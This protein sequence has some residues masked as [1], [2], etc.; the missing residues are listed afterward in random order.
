MDEENNLQ[1]QENEQVQEPVEETVQEQVEEVVEET[2]EATDEV[3]EEVVEEPVEEAAEE[4][5]E[6]VV[7][8]PATETVQEPV[9]SNTTTTT[10]ETKSSKKGL[11]IGIIV[12]VVVI[13]AVVAAVL[14]F[15]KNGGKSIAGK[16]SLVEMTEGEETYSQE[17]LKALEVFGLTVSLELNE[18][19]T[20]KL[21]LFGEEMNLT[22]DD[23]NMYYEGQ[24]AP[25]KV[26]GKKV[27][28][29][30][31]GAKMTFEKNENK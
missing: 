27:S 19:K 22:Y 13:A 9:E 1:E 10:V 11:I 16:Y 8:E 21:V 26:D 17:Q 4:V 30:Q 14:L 15:P 23:K 31:E 5:V 7:E 6:E 29:E 18:D 24:P 12:A 20:G 28:L 3:A 2:V 25:Y